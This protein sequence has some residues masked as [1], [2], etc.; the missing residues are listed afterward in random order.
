MDNCDSDVKIASGSKDMSSS[1]GVLG[2]RYTI[3]CGYILW[4][5]LEKK[6]RLSPSDCAKYLAS[7]PPEQL[8]HNRKFLSLSY[9]QLLLIHNE[10]ICL[11][12]TNTER[13][14]AEKREW[15]VNRLQGKGYSSYND[16]FDFEGRNFKSGIWKSYNSFS[17]VGK[18]SPFCDLE[19]NS[20]R[21]DAFMPLEY[22]AC[23]EENFRNPR[24]W[25]WNHFLHLSEIRTRAYGTMKCYCYGNYA[26][27][28]IERE[29]EEH[30]F[31]QNLPEDVKS[32]FDQASMYA[33]ATLL[34]HPYNVRLVPFALCLPF[35]SPF[36]FDRPSAIPL[37][38]YNKYLV[39]LNAA[40]MELIAD[41]MTEKEEVDALVQAKKNKKQ[42]DAFNDTTPAKSDGC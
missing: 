33:M 6:A 4:D 20:N 38:A 18:F 14:C 37:K 8:M 25:H 11:C 35:Q 30:R 7:L 41:I 3:L 16:D 9:W 13:C 19:I 26:T 1:Y 39:K 29:N 10:R 5:E 36:Y 15:K 27:R 34:T 32:F 23:E 12:L 17:L 42:R 22:L 24:F 21:F 40:R 28:E 2:T 31:C